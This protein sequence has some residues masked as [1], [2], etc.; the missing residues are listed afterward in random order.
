M[1]KG[2][3]GPTALQP[4]GRPSA[5][6]PVRLGRVLRN[7]AIGNYFKTSCQA[8]AIPV[9]TATRWR[10]EGEQEL[11]RIRP[12]LPDVEIH[13]MAWLEEHGAPSTLET[14]DANATWW[15][16]IPPWCRHDRWLHVV[17]AVLLT[18][19]RARAEAAHVRNVRRAAEQDWRASAWFLE[20]T[21]PQE[22]GRIDR[23]E[24]S[25]AEGG[26]VQVEEVTVDRLVA[27]IAELRG[28]GND[29]ERADA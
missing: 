12:T 26:P 5:I 21:R 13:V 2:Q 1:P 8:A 23:V 15:G 14:Y 3:A 16:T 20:R 11:E 6:N 9:M 17:F 27:R 29:D 18:H 4:I 19:A 7:M 10:Q 28:S 22:F 25:G 24:H